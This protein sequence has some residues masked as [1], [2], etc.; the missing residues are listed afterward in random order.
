[1]FTK[2]LDFG[3]YRNIN[4]KAKRIILFCFK[5]FVA[6]SNYWKLVV[7]AR[8]SDQPLSSFS[9]PSRRPRNWAASTGLDQ[10]SLVV[11]WVGFW[12]Q[13]NKCWLAWFC[14]LHQC[15][16][17][18]HLELDHFWMFGQKAVWIFSMLCCV[19][20]RIQ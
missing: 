15:I 12:G 16:W 19:F 8:P 5:S 4:L 6:S 9:W 14:W 1:M 3:L 11:R 17:G 2:I 10:R 20:N 7:V 13:L 18:R